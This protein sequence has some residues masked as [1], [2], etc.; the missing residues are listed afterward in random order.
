MADDKKR[1]SFCKVIRK[2]FYKPDGTVIPFQQVMR[3]Y[4]PA[5]D[6]MN[7]GAGTFKKSHDNISAL[8]RQSG[9]SF[10]DQ[11][12]DHVRNS[13]DSELYWQLR[14][15]LISYGEREVTEEDTSEFI[16]RMRADFWKT[17]HALGMD[18]RRITEAARHMD[19][20][21][22]SEDGIYRIVTKLVTGRVHI[23][24][25]EAGDE[26]PLASIKEFARQLPDDDLLKD[27][28]FAK[29]VLD[30]AAEKYMPL[31]IENP[32]SALERIERDIDT[33]ESTNVLFILTELKAMFTKA[34]SLQIE[35]AVDKITNPITKEV[36]EFPSVHQKI[37]VSR[38][39]E[40]HY[41]LLGDEM[42]TG[43]TAQAILAFVHLCN[44]E[45]DRNHKALIVAPANVLEHWQAEI[46]NYLVPEVAEAYKPVV[47]RSSNKDKA[48]EQAKDAKVVLISYDMVI[49]SLN[50]EG[51]TDDPDALQVTPQEA[52]TIC[53]EL[54][55]MGF[56]Y[57][58]L[59][60]AHRA[61]NPKFASQAALLGAQYLKTSK[62]TLLLCESGHEE[63]W[64]QELDSFCGTSRN[65]PQVAVVE[66]PSAD[67]S[68]AEIVVCPRDMAVYLDESM[69]EET[70]DEC[71]LEE[72]AVCK[73]AKVV[74]D[75]VVD[76]SS[77]RYVVLLT[78]TPIVNG[79]EDIGNL[80]SMLEPEHFPTPAIFIEQARANP[81][82]VREFLTR[83]ML[84]RRV[85]H[86][87]LRLPSCTVETLEVDFPDAQWEVYQTVQDNLFDAPANL[88]L[89]WTRM[90]A[91]APSLLADSV[92]VEKLSTK[93][94]TPLREVQINEIERLRALAR[95][96]PSEKFRV[97][98]EIAKAEAAQGRKTVIFTSI[99]RNG[100][101]E[102]LVHQLRAAG[103]SADH[104]DGSVPQAEREKIRDRFQEEDDPQVLVIMLSTM[105]EGISLTAASTVV[106][107]DYP[108]TYAELRQGIARLWRPGQKSPV[109]AVFLKAPATVDENAEELV[110]NKEIIAL[111]E[112]DG[113]APT[114][115][116]K[117]KYGEKS[118]TRAF[119]DA[120][121]TPKEIL[122]G[123]YGNMMGRGA[124][125]NVEY[126]G[127]DGG[128]NARSFL[129]NYLF[130]WEKSSSANTA[131]AIKTIVDL[132][133]QKESL[134]R[135]ADL[136]GGP[137]IF[138][139]ISGRPTTC[140]D[141]NQFCLRRAERD[142]KD[143]VVPV[144]APLHDLPLPSES[145]DLA[146]M[147][148]VLHYAPPMPVV[149]NVVP[150]PRGAMIP[151]YS[152]P[153][154]RELIFR[155]AFRILRPGGW[156]LLSEVDKFT[157]L[158]GILLMREG[159]AALGAETELAGYASDANGG[160]FN[161]FLLAARKIGEP[162]SD[163]LKP[164]QFCLDSEHDVKNLRKRKK[165]PKTASEDS[166]SKI[167]K[168]VFTS[169]DGDEKELGQ[170]FGDVK[171]SPVEA[172]PKAPHPKTVLTAEQRHSKFV[173][174]KLDE[175]GKLEEIAAEEED[176]EMVYEQ[177]DSLAEIDH[178]NALKKIAHC[179]LNLASEANTD[180]ERKYILSE[181]VKAGKKASGNGTAA[182][183]KKVGALSSIVMS[184]PSVPLQD[185]EVIKN[186]LG[187]IAKQKGAAA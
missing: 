157:N 114:E 5:T 28:A 72:Y 20:D 10:N 88:K 39:H 179:L 133:A 54:K 24:H 123:H 56:T 69:F 174:R 117:R 108:N 7:P 176:L 141:I 83:R 86:V 9:L 51:S 131:R 65:P 38:I 90:A 161:I 77:D 121:K 154:E 136:G 40:D 119:S 146:V 169:I 185:F 62:K 92:T 130:N 162:Q 8:S 48:V 128:K 31:F 58:V 81:P 36:R 118:K 116:Q 84:R 96:M 104:I 139:R 94:K 67:F 165:P 100:I 37:G 147:S 75:I 59:D 27:K 101:V 181:V 173:D 33:E 122:L 53:S 45:P 32:A 134:E 15:T 3:D 140:V 26:D 186:K 142:F 17:A 98:T 158:E 149:R 91:L 124:A 41:L 144:H 43:K 148:L 63:K 183:L 78:G 180:D 50:G 95:G 155:E 167:E 21:L 132:V 35:G 126:L 4:D 99:L 12:L 80:A 109:K 68:A 111:Q 129:L 145:H 82:L 187:Q 70:Y 172:K 6:E 14:T 138:T 170:A 159:L 79:M 175:L 73:R 115:E 29:L 57:F 46:G 22:A 107:L 97:A 18:A 112:V 152:L 120:L 55:K 113:I 163:N 49:R 178:E 25:T 102:P 164:E 16:K 177:L 103:L 44:I 61:K 66:D 11:L 93:R 74:Q 153:S 42:G 52:R 30:G 47:I 184:S 13:G 34:N 125:R 2:R 151:Q 19:P 171:P 76:G 89:L 137:A 156:L 60:E 105:S 64:K 135:I 87:D 71:K 23:Q 106:Y 85:E 160:K 1:G 127:S 182:A 150:G 168:F 110:E 143:L 166:G